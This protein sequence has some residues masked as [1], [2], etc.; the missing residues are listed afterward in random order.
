MHYPTIAELSSPPPGRTGWPWTEESP[1]LPD[2][3]ADGAPWPRISIVTPSY[4]QGQFIE[5]TIRSVLLQGYPNLEY[6]IMDGGSTD[7]TVEIIRK[8]ERWLSYWQSEQDRGQ[9]S[10][11]NAGWR[12]STGAAITWLNSDDVLT[13]GS[14]FW[15]AQSLFLGEGADLVYGDNII[16]DDFS[17]EQY[18][19]AGRPYDR[20]SVILKAA[21][22]IQQPGFLMRRSM[23]Q[24]VGD[25][26]ESFHFAMDFDYWVRATLRGIRVEYVPQ[27]LAMFREHPNAKTSTA[28]VTR[29]NDRYHV[30]KKTFDA[31]ETPLERKRQRKRAAAYVESNA[32]YI[33]YKAADDARAIEHAWQHMKLARLHTSLLTLG[34]LTV[35]SLRQIGGRWIGANHVALV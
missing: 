8:Y 27:T 7:N 6:I 24:I 32:A 28:H 31:P 15:V 26:D 16:I 11:I 5:E 35:S 3:M 30:F 34:V 25:L 14:L 18:R 9:A 13:S 1:P 19:V 17:V 21:N 4:N 20:E 22:P 2:T 12:R 23:L 10:A 33:A 29:I